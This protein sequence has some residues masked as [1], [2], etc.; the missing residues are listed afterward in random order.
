MKRA[1]YIGFMLILFA[2]ILCTPLFAQ[3]STTT[4]SQYVVSMDDFDA[5]VS[6]WNDAV[7][8]DEYQ[9]YLEKIIQMTSAE[10]EQEYYPFMLSEL[11]FFRYF[12]PRCSSMPVFSELNKK[13]DELIQT[14]LAFEK[15]SPETFIAHKLFEVV[16]RLY[17]NDDEVPPA[18]NKV[19]KRTVELPDSAIV[20]KNLLDTISE[21]EAMYLRFST[22]LA[23]QSGN[24]ALR[25]S[26]DAYTKT[27]NNPALVYVIVN[28][29]TFGLLKEALEKSDNMTDS[30]IL[31][32]DAALYYNFVC[33]IA[34]AKTLFAKWGVPINSVLPEDISSLFIIADTEPF[35]LTCLD[36]DVM[37][38]ASGIA[39]YLA[40]SGDMYISRINRVVNS[41][42][43]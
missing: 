22:M 21:A 23:K 5:A 8:K 14:F 36:I 26:G 19:Y 16:S 20:R 10:I 35:L 43:K 12:A 13:A 31:E 3:S 7:Q 28:E 34:I 9:H 4:S 18:E 32:D 11:V 15:D 42:G 2:A 17:G 39:S 1:G 29:P 25:F 30:L 41:T 27:M 6:L 24:V 33:N 38:K 40:A 37:K